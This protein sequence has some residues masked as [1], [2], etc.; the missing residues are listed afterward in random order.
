MKTISNEAYK[1]LIA[2][3]EFYAEPANYYV[4]ESPTHTII[5]DDEGMRAQDALQAL[6]DEE[7]ESGVVAHG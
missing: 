7:I 3:I 6:Q 4:Q 2:A 5:D 1:K